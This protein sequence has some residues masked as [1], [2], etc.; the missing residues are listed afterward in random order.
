MFLRERERAQAVGISAAKHVL[1]T[2]TEARIPLGL[3]CP[4]EL[5]VLASKRSDLSCSSI[6]SHHMI[7]QVA[8]T[9]RHHEMK[10][11]Q[12]KL[13]AL[14]ATDGS[15]SYNHAG[16]EILASVNG[17][18]EVQRRDEIPNEVYLEVNVREASGVGGTLCSPYLYP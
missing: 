10:E 15:A 11:P 1:A 6:L 8:N 9:R 13:T 3:K 12:V 7:I 14:P 16:Y 18:L 17:P 5:D 2:V 4:D